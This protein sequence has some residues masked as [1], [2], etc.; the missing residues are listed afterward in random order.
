[1]RLRRCVGCGG[2]FAPRPQV[3]QQR[4][5]AAAACQRE[6]RRQWNAARRQ[7]PDYRANQAR[8]QRAW[9]EA[10]RDYWRA[11]RR[12]HPE[13]SDAKRQRQRERD[14]RRRAAAAAGDLAKSAACEADLPVRSGTYEL[15]PVVPHDLAKSAAWK[16]QITV[17]STG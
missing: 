11:Y 4:F 13:Y 2:L 15:R 6:R 9:S 12:D 3:P 16:V 7:D 5:C 14:R 17:L 8:A 10:H 1:M